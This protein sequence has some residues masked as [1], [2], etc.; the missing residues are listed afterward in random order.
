MSLDA[1]ITPFD[2]DYTGAFGEIERFVA[3]LKDH[4]AVLSVTPESMPLDINPRN[5]LVGEVATTEKRDEAVFS[6]TIVIR[7]GDEK[8]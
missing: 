2:G 8:V 6:L 4:A 7:T 3:R 5:S 1:R